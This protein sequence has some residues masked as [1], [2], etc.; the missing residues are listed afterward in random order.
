VP[1]PESIQDPWR[2]LLPDNGP[3]VFTHGDLRPANIIVT[4][5][6]PVKI[7]AIVDWEQAGW[8]PDYWEQCKAKFTAGHDEDWYAWIDVFL[9]PHEAALDAFDFYTFTLGIL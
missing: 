5:A 2:D 8:Y 9:E 7:V 3:T 6:N 4:A 1:D